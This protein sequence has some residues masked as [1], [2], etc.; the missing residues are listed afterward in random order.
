MERAT[1]FYRDI[2]GGNV[3]Y[4]SPHWTSLS[5][6]G[7]SLGLHPAIGSPHAIRDVGHKICFETENLDVARKTLTESGVY[8]APVD[9]ET[10]NGR[11][12]DF[13]DTEGNGFQMMQPQ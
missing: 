8:V 2:L 10:P 11:I 5:L 3:G 1:R 13:E 6:G 7:I 9:H 4:A 12:F